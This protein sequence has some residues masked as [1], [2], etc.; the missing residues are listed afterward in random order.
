MPD[1]FQGLLLK[2][3]ICLLIFNQ[4]CGREKISKYKITPPESPGVEKNAYSENL[5]PKANLEQESQCIFKEEMPQQ[6]IAY[7][8]MQQNRSLMLQKINQQGLTREHAIQFGLANNPNLFAYFENLEIVMQVSS[9]EVCGK[10]QLF[11]RAHDFLMIL[12]RRS[13][14]GM[15]ERL[16]F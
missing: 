6:N 10:I 11:Q 13:I 16:A 9:K 8:G 2:F 14:M 7:Y 12:K 3:C 1:M 5:D 4:A 15:I